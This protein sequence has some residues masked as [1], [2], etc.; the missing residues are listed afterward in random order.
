MLLPVC[1]EAQ[2]YPHQALITDGNRKKE[3]NKTSVCRFCFSPSENKIGGG[4]IYSGNLKVDCR[5]GGYAIGAARQEDQ[6][7]VGA[8][9]GHDKTHR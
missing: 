3:R 1:G 6:R 4:N 7:K 9:L 8:A 5:L 2:G